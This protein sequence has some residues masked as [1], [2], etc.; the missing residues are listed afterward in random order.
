VIADHQTAALIR[1][2]RRYRGEAI[3]HTVPIRKR[4]PDP[5]AAA[6]TKTRHLSFFGPH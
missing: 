2:E 4:A 1:S 3:S 5:S 6:V